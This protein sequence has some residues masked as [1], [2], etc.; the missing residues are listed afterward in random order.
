MQKL[1]E[2]KIPG[3]IRLTDLPYPKVL[4]VAVRCFKTVEV[5]FF[6]LLQLL[7]F[8][9]LQK[10]VVAIP[11]LALRNV[12]SLQA[13]V[14]NGTQEEILGFR[15]RALIHQLLKGVPDVEMFERVSFSLTVSENTSR[16]IEANTETRGFIHL[17]V[18][19][20]LPWKPSKVSW[21]RVTP[22]GVDTLVGRIRLGDYEIIN[23]PVFF[24]TRDIEWVLV[25][26]ID[27]TIKDSNIAKTTG[28]KQIVSSIFKGHYYRYDALAGMAELYRELEAK[29]V[30]IIYVT[31]TPYALAPFLMKFLQS[32]GFPL[33]P[34]FPRWLGYGRF[35]HKWRT[36]HRI[37]S[38]LEH[39]KMIFIGDSGEQDLQ[40]YRRLNDT[41]IFSK[42]IQKI[43]IRHV[44][45]TPMQKL[46]DSKEAYYG[47]IAELRL[48]LGSFF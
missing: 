1:Q 42:H 13:V 40:I 20:Q 17:Q 39:Q 37:L 4:G 14:Y 27:D 12:T 30:L 9:R 31:S 33:G 47:D 41:E 44:P 22:M 25:S 15:P 7:G 45:G 36:I 28:F 2:I 11:S 3:R 21:L 6:R 38:N 16:T 46:L 48:M 24:L 26:D 10:S 23:S 34:V 18:P 5:L 19:W 43:L 35:R 32:N 8:Y 29:G